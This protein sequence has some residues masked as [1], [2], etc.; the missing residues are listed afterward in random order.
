MYLQEMIGVLLFAGVDRVLLSLSAGVD[1]GVIV[2]K[3]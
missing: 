3:S 1:Q 2:C